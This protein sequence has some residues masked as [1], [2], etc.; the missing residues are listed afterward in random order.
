MKPNK[1]AKPILI[2]STRHKD[3][4]VNI[5]TRKLHDFVVEEEARPG[6]VLYPRDQALD[7]QLV[8]K[9]KDVQD[10]A[11]LA[12]PVVPIYIQKGIPP[13]GIRT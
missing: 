3:K 1:S 6:Q 13:R 12:V 11:D 7:P 5:P 10:A 9:G 2:E 8:W 4:R